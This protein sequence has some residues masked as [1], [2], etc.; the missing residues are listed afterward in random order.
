M[1]E[2]TTGE[3]AKMT[4]VSIRTIQ[5]YDKKNILKP[6]Q[7]SSGG[8]RIY[9]D[10]EVSRLKLILLL[11]NLG[12]SLKA[13]TEILDSQNSTAVLDLLLDQQLKAAKD[14]VRITKGQIKQMEDL[15]KNL[16]Q[17]SQTPIKTIDDIDNLMSN[18]K[19]L[20]K[21]HIKMVVYGLLMD[22]VEI[23]S[24]VWGITKN[25]WQPFIIAMLIA[26]IFAIGITRYYFRE[27]NYICPN[28]NYEFKPK[29]WAAFWSGH[30]IHA[31]KLVCPNC[32]Q[33]NYCVEVY[34][35]KRNMGLA[36]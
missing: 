15:R 5:Y 17:I 21:V 29:F 35:E 24:L 4:N 32:H 23:G 27:V 11:K 25:Q 3:L 2:Y 28:C 7:I 13:I 10:T 18:K 36:K 9:T 34:D 12:L 30:N 6:H 33:K 19:S 14:Q 31:R 22:V 1:S 16:P 20:R 26:V 8:S